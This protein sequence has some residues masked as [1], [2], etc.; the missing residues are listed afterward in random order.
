MTDAKTKKEAKKEAKKPAELTIQFPLT[1][2]AKVHAA[3][4]LFTFS[5]NGQTFT[6]SYDAKILNITS[7]NDVVA[8]KV[9]GK[10]TRAK[11]A[12]AYSI[13]AH[14]RN[15]T[16]GAAGEY[17][18]EM[19]IIF[20]HFPVTIE[21]KGKDVFIK[22]FLG[23]KQPRMAKI[24][25]NAKIETSGQIIT[26]KGHNKEDVG[27]TANNLKRATKITNKDNRIFQDG[28]YYS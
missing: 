20:A 15:M 7:T 27:Q 4:G 16:K 13:N 5:G 9:I 25:G 21:V 22:N 10:P 14:L 1:N 8:I 18:K 6:K 11:T 26:I 17:T 2:G 23:E 28:I 3:N 12:Q 19:Q 24:H